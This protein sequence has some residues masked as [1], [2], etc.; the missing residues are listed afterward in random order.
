M[1]TKTFILIA[2]MA[3]VSLQLVSAQSLS[4]KVSKNVEE[5]R[6]QINTLSKEKIN[7]LDQIAFRIYK[8][9]YNKK[10][11]TVTLIDQTNTKN[12]Q[13]AMIWLK[14]GFKYYNIDIDVQSAGISIKNNQIVNLDTLNDYGFSVQT[15]N[16]GKPDNYWVVYSRSGSWLVFQKSLSEIKNNGDD[17]VKIIVDKELRDSDIANIKLDLTNE[18]LPLHIIYIAAQINHLIKNKI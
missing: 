5:L 2:V 17:S 1:N 9:C 3:L 6:T 15:A 18:N 12:S 13:L 11:A 4:K 8:N 14:T 7:E 16:N 10:D